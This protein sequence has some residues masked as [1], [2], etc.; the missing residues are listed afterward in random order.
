MKEYISTII[1]VS[2]FSIIIELILPNNKL[3]KYIGVLIS[4]V[5]IL[6]LISPLIDVFNNEEIIKTISNTVQDIKLN[7]TGNVKSYD[8]SDY[9]DRIIFNSV[10]TKL[11]KEVLSGCQNEFKDKISVKDVK[12]G[13]N[14]NYEIT[15]VDIYIEKVSDV[16]SAYEIISFIEAK[17]NIKDYLINILEE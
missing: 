5:I 1:Y 10:K 12:I 15:E 8:F 4:L 9:K 17:Y 6:I 11:E 14:N 13:L 16:F 2:I 3:K 7:V